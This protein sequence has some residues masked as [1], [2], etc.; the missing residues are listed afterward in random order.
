MRSR[1]VIV[2][3]RGRGSQTIERTWCPGELKEGTVSLTGKRAALLLATVVTVLATA[4]CVCIGEKVDLIDM[5]TESHSVE[6]DGAERVAVEL[7]MGIGTLELSGGSDTLLDAEFRY[8][9]AEWEPV[10]SYSVNGGR[11][12]L[13]IRQPQSEGKSFPRNAENEWILRL[14]EDVP[15]TIDIDLGVGKARMYLGDLDLRDLT[16]DHGVGDLMINLA[17]EWTNDLT[18][19]I[20][21]GVGKLVLTVPSSIGVRLDTDTGIGSVSTHGFTKR[22]GVMVNDAYDT[23]G[24]QIDVSIDAGIG[25]ITVTASDTGVTGV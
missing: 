21:G 12:R 9:V 11:G 19:R 14:N 15:M 1:S 20:D 2:F 25:S 23:G 8:N 16:V 13:L 24:A 10:V 17:G 3:E 18:A 5:R 22:G 7:E 4:S 6:L